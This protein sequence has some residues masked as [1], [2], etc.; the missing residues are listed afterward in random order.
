VTGQAKQCKKQNKIPI[1]IAFGIFELVR[2][3]FNIF[4]IHFED[5]RVV[6]ITYYK[7]KMREN[8]SV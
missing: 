7:M 2:A 4:N 5:I 1:Y 6:R 8:E 3:K